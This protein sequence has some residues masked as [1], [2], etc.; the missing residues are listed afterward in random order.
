MLAADPLPRQR[1][2]GLTNPSSAT[3]AGDA[4]LDNEKE[5]AA[6]LCSLERVVRPPAYRGPLDRRNGERGLRRGNDGLC[7]REWVN[8]DDDDLAKQTVVTGRT[9]GDAATGRTGPDLPSENPAKKTQGLTDPS[10]AT[11][12]GEVKLAM[13]NQPERRWL[14]AGARG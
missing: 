7:R 9:E 8:E 4:R 6:S 3:E 11:G 5:R 13:Q 12:T 10:S 14:F 1:L 2:L